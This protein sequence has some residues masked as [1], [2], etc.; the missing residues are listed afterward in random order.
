M[1]LKFLDL[2]NKLEETNFE[3]NKEGKKELEE[4]NKTLE[5]IESSIIEILSP[6]LKDT[7]EFKKYLRVVIL[8]AINVSKQGNDKFDK[9]YRIDNITSG[10][11]NSLDT[12]I[13]GNDKTLAPFLNKLV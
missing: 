13:Y 8:N 9:I 1:K 4:Y 5:K 10:G 7:N 11:K 2:M 6:Y 12:H 3:I